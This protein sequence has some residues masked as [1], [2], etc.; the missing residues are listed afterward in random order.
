MTLRFLA[1]A[2]LAALTLV[3]SAARSAEPVRITAPGQLVAGDPLWWTVDGLAPGSVVRVHGVAAYPRYE[4][5]AS[6]R[7]VPVRKIVHAWADFQVGEDGKV[8]GG[9]AAPIG[10]TY[11]QADGL[12]LIWSGYVTGDPALPVAMPDGVEAVAA[13]DETIHLRVE[14]DGAI[15]AETALSLR[16]GRE[17]TVMN[18]VRG[19]GFTGSFARPR[20]SVGRP[21]VIV[22]HGSEGGG[23]INRGRAQDLAAQGFVVLAID[24]FASPSENIA[25]IPAALRSIPLDP[26]A[27]ARAWLAA[28]PEVDPRRIALAGTSRGAEMALLA[29]SHGLFD[30][31]V[32]ACVPSDLMWPGYGDNNV[33]TEDYPSWTLRGEPLPF[34]PF[35]RDEFDRGRR[36]PTGTAAFRA[37]EVDHIDRLAAARIPVETIAA[38][39]MLLGAEADTTWHSG[40]MARRIDIRRSEAGLADRTRTVVY[41]GAGHQICGNGAWPLRL[42]G[43]DG[44]GDANLSMQ[45]EGEATV[46]AWKQTIAFLTEVLR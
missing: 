27:D 6:G 33:T 7:W 13:D 2:G 36:F 12:G 26:I 17:D 28:R 3:A 11:R 4:P 23:G 34:V 10:G 25:G 9:A 35:I 38:P 37:S 46:D 45:A 15:V 18:T 19:P 32:L 39:V 42:Y 40:E 43:R 1:A 20:D 8:N 41:A 44:E 14:V 21:A 22:L 31:P 24:Y 16:R 30:G 29:A 5:D